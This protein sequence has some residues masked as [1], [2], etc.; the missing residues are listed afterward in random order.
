MKLSIYEPKLEDLWFRQKMLEDEETMSYNKAWGGTISFP[1]RD[2]E[3]WFNHW[4][5]NHENKR[6]YRYL[7]N[8]EGEFAGEIAYHYDSNYDGYMVDII[9]YSKYRNKGYG[10]LG[11][12]LL[13]D[14]AKENGISSLHDDIALDNQGISIFKKLDFIEQYRT[15]SIILLKKVL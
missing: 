14:I 11:L 4:V 13:C 7:K 9:I 15:D 12:K 1:K 6:Y 8:E 10:S 3:D 2:W 5:I